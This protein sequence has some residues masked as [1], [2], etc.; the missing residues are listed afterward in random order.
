MRMMRI[1]M[2]ILIIGFLGIHAA[3]YDVKQDQNNLVKFISD[4]PIEDFEGVT[5]QVDGYLLWNGP[6]QLDGA[7]FYFEVDLNTLDTGIG[8][9]NRHMRENYLNTDRY[10]KATYKG[11]IIS[12]KQIGKNHFKVMTE[13]EFYCHGVTQKRQ[14]PGEIFVNGNDLRIKSA[15]DVK[16][17]DHQIKIPSIMFYKIDENMQVQADFN[18]AVVKEKNE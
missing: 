11:K 6:K 17:S 14:I 3:E 9:R 1:L 12:A 5:S 10:P 15:F 13:G 8:L 4:A 18:L 7:D 2:V 16:L